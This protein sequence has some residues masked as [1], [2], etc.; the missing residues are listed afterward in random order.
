MAEARGEVLLSLVFNVAFSKVYLEACII[1]N[2]YAVYKKILYK[3]LE[4]VI[5]V[6]NV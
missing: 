3:S 2:D 4:A 5:F 6:K 1:I